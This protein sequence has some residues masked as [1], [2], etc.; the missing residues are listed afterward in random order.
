[1]YREERLQAVPA[2]LIKTNGKS[3]SVIGDDRSM[4]FDF[5][6]RSMVICDI[7]IPYSIMMASVNL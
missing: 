7:G 5:N 2:P 4:G 1:V 6:T 3:Y